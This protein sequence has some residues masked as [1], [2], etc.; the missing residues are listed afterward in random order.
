M[1]TWDVCRL[2]GQPVVARDRTIA[3]MRIYP[4]V[5]VWRMMAEEPFMNSG[6]RQQQVNQSACAVKAETKKP[7]NQKH[8]KNRLEHVDLLRSLERLERLPIC[9]R[10]PERTTGGTISEI[11]RPF[12]IAGTLK[13]ICQGS[14]FCA[15]LLT[16]HKNSQPFA[17][18]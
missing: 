7:Q 10:Q 3:R 11:L 9:P 18:R 4:S 15:R 1:L 13:M 6:C 16:P 5:L 2:I 14:L 8:N 17:L 12:R